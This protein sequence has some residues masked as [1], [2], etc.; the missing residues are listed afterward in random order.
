MAPGE[1]EWMSGAGRVMAGFPPAGVATREGN[2]SGRRV[3]VLV[4][5]TL[6]KAVSNVEGWQMRKGGIACIPAKA[7]SSEPSVT[8]GTFR[9]VRSP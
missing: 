6:R 7:I 2:E 5:T 3:Q 9:Q 4:T 8:H 1:I